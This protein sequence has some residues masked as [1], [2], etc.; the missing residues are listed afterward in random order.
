MSDYKRSGFLY[1][2][3]T[4]L[5]PNRLILKLLWIFAIITLLSLK[6]FVIN[7]NK[8]DNGQISLLTVIINSYAAGT[9]VIYSSI[10]DFV[11]KYF[12][13]SSNASIPIGDLIFGWLFLVGGIFAMF[14]LGSIIV[15]I[16]DADIGDTASIFLKL[17]LTLVFVFVAAASSH[18]LGG[19]SFIAQSISPVAESIVNQTINQ[20]LINASNI[21]QE[22]PVISLK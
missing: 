21:S 2:M 6:E 4:A 17:G 9:Q 16:L 7:L 5:S 22:I 10:W 1:S 15:D 19:E 8:W 12:M 14:Q 11:T 18:F 13:S 20:S 3:I